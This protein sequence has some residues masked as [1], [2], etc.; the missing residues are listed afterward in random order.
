[1]LSSIFRLISVLH[2]DAA[3]DAEGATETAV[4]AAH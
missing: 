3:V 4:Q 2:P 1:L